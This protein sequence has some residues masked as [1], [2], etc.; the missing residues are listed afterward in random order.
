MIASRGFVFSSVISSY[1]GLSWPKIRVSQESCDIVAGG[2]D[3]AFV[4]AAPLCAH[5]RAFVL[6]RAVR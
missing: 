1:I 6:Y 4:A 2:S 5:S 3:G